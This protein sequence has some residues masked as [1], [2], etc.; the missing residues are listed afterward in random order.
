MPSSL[1]TTS[2]VASLRSMSDPELCGG[3]GNGEDAEA[4]A[5]NGETTTTLRN[6]DIRSSEAEDVAEETAAA[7]E[8]E[9]PA[10]KSKTLPVNGRISALRLSA[11]RGKS[12]SLK[13][14]IKNPFGGT[15][16]A[17]A[18]V[19]ARIKKPK[20][21][22]GSEPVAM[23]EDEA[24][25]SAAP[26]VDPASSS[27]SPSVPSKFAL[28][29]LFQRILNQVNASA[30]AAAAASSGQAANGR[31]RYGNTA[32]ASE[33]KMAEWKRRFEDGK[34]P[35][36]VG[37]KNHGNTC[38]INAILQCLNHTD[39]LAEYFVLDAYKSDL[40]RKRRISN[41]AS[42]GKRA[43]SAASGGAAGGGGG[44]ANGSR[45]EV[46]EQL[47]TLL[48]SMWSLQYDPEISIRFKSLVEKHASQYKGSS[49]HDAQEF[50]LWLL[51]QVR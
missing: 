14:T 15:S 12:S 25:A 10:S 9:E 29:H 31:S 47:A 44:G 23:N 16:G 45:G 30:M 5:H 8:D 1:T 22:E 37:I 38:F 50:L 51:D 17:A 6:E 19:A 43:A 41:L 40:R 28:R 35:G 3:N 39:L 33:E 18:A 49:Q 24:S 11:M 48:K 27:P 4:A 21:R 34:V 26:P 13:R 7:A 46:T 36:V 32:A 2:N 42:F 20:K